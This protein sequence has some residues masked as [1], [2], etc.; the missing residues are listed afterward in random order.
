MKP[1]WHFGQPAIPP[2][3]AVLSILALAVPLTAA[4]ADVGRFEVLLWLTALIPVLLLAY[5]RGWPGIAVGLAL[6]MVA[7]SMIQVYLI[8]SGQRAP[9]WPLMLAVTAALVLLSLLAGAVTDQ[10]HSARER[11]ERLALIDPLTHLPN[12][13]YFDVMLEREVAAAQRGR[14]L[15]VVAFDLDGLK[16]I[17]DR[18]GHAVGDEVIKAFAALLSSNTRSMNLSARLGGD[19]FASIVSSSTVEGAL[20]F[21]E[22]I[23]RATRGME[24]R[25]GGIT[26]TAGVAAYH[27]GIHDAGSLLKAADEALYQAKANRGSYAVRGEP[28]A[29]VAVNA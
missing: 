13:R 16:G 21:V 1:R 22:R 11:A 26:V 17:N 25:A 7:F 9:D 15:A 20:V 12:R 4:M 10:L 5:Y 27:A 29:H 23:Q 2:R 18:H 6:A 24:H 8:G 19:E 3:A 14:E 28:P